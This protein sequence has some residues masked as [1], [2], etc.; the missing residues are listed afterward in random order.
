MKKYLIYL[1]YY[2]CFLILVIFICSILNLIGVNS[3][4]TNLLLFLF[5]ALAF[6]YFS[7]KTGKK[8]SKKG[9]VAGLK[10][11]GILLLLL[12]IIN[13]LT[14]HKLFSIPT[15]I[16]YLVLLLVGALGGMIGIN[17]KEDN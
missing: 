17:K 7:F 1:G 8:A 11:S 3:T 15:I 12:I 9:Y 10:I 13:I 2:T 16:Y 6:F 5:N 4:I 14:T